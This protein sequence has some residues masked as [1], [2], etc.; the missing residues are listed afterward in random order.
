MASWLRQFGSSRRILGVT[1]LMLALA[2]SCSL[3]RKLDPYLDREI[4]GPVTITSEWLEIKPTEPLSPMRQQQE[5][6]LD[7]AGNHHL[8]LTAGDMILQ[9]GSANK[10][11]VQMIDEYMNVYNANGHTLSGSLLGFFVY[12]KSSGKDGLP[13][14]RTYIKVR[15]RSDKPIQCSRILWRGYYPSDLK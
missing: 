4:S 9:D 12:D 5:I 15:I 2:A 8:E 7:I 14:D 1:L 11:E 6:V 13:Q 10:F 3:Y